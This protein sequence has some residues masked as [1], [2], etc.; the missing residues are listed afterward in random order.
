MPAIHMVKLGER[1]ANIL[2]T[3]METHRAPDFEISN[4]GFRLPTHSGSRFV[5]RLES[6]PPFKL[7]LENLQQSITETL[8]C[9]SNTN[10]LNVM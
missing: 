2:V 6:P 10:N 3:N 4:E 9:V 5:G 7:T 8:E 1:L